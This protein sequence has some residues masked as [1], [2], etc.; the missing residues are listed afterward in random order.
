MTERKPPGRSFTS[1]ID[2][3]I[4]EAEERGSFD[5]LPGAGKPLPPGTRLEST[6]AVIRDRVKPRGLPTY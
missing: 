1:W 5:N 6:V 3:Q 2:Q 4:N